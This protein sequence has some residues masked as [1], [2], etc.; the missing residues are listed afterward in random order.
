[1]DQPYRLHFAGLLVLPEQR[2]DC[3]LSAQ[4]FCR[5]TSPGN[6]TRLKEHYFANCN[7]FH[8]IVSHK[9]HR[10]A[11]LAMKRLQLLQNGIFQF[12]VERSQR[13]VKEK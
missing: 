3:E 11:E 13:L 5:I 2:V 7:G 10:D 1:M 4:K 6:S 12:R 9:E 8:S